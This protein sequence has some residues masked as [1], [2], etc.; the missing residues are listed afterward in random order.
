MSKISI[1]G[2]GNVGATTA[3]GL[4]EKDFGDIVLLDIIDGRAQGK[5]LDFAHSAHVQG[6]ISHISGTN[7]YQHSAQ[8]ICNISP[9]EN[10]R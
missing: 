5:A 1:I 4:I 2:A 7:R 10:R 6:F 3:Q 8:L 9:R